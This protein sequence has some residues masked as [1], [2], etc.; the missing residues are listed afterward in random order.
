M[1]ESETLRHRRRSMHTK[2]RNP[3]WKVH[4][5]AVILSENYNQT[6]ITNCKKHLPYPNKLRVTQDRLR[7]TCKQCMLWMW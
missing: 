4:K 6:A 5:V 1:I 3:Y 2:T 7:V